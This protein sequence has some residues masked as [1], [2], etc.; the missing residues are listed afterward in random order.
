MKKKIIL[1]MFL[2]ISI[3]TISLF[4]FAEEVSSKE[5]V[6]RVEGK[7]TTH[8]NESVEWNG[9]DD[10]LT[11]LKTAIGEDNITGSEGQYG[12]MI[13]SLFGESGESGDGYTTSFGLY[14]DKGEGLNS[15]S[16]GIS[17]LTLDDVESLVLHSK[18]TDSFYADLTF[19]PR[20]EMDGQVLKVKKEVT[21]YDENWN[22]VIT[23]E[24]F[25]GAIVQIDGGETTNTTGA[26]I[27]IEL[28]DFDKKGYISDSNGEINLS[29]MER[30]S[31]K[32][33]VKK[34]GENY[35]ILIRSE[36]NLEKGSD[37]SSDY[38]NV[39]DAV[40][41]INEYINLESK[42]SWRQSLGKLYSADEISTSLYDSIENKFELSTTES[43]SAYA[44]NIFG[45]IASG[46]DPYDYGGINYVKKLED[47]QDENGKFIIG[48]YDDHPATLAYVVLALDAVNGNYNNEKAI[49][50][51]ISDQDENGLIRDIDTTAMVIAALTNHKDSGNVND[52]ISKGLDYI[53]GQQQDNGGF[54]AWGSDNPYTV[55]TVINAVI[56]NNEDPL[57]DEWTKNGNTMLDA[58]MTYKVNNHFENT[59]EYGTDVDGIT[60]QAYITL[61]SL[62]RQKLVYTNIEIDSEEAER[63]ENEE[64]LFNIEQVSSG[65]YKNGEMANVQFKF[66][67][68]SSSDQEIIMVIGLYDDDSN[69]L[70]NYSYFFDTVKK[71]ENEQFGSGTLIP[72][73][74]NYKIKAFIWD[75][76]D[77]QKVILS[78]PIVIDV[79][80]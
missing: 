60:E 78:T 37:Y 23:E 44:G 2:L 34:D 17:S 19:L 70:V 58:L 42:F 4:C 45:I 27:S 36:I 28:N 67:N 79:E 46:R 18:A 61:N 9:S 80:K 73:S 57:S 25:S 63:P 35:P 33:S 1:S 24:P 40:D 77:S 30:G 54:I 62:M 48:T 21:S 5:I 55:C 66:E 72:D 31:F 64:S 50:A 6:V 20:L 11:F 56:A 3:L 65:D 43:A 13:E 69:E 51:L 52:I 16:V 49:N 74:G 38:S 15:S 76:F 39:I 59:T 29:H 8:F 68:N 7:E 71:G 22:P 41:D 32:A 26:A 53:K 12:F 10:A 14:V 75:S 47:A